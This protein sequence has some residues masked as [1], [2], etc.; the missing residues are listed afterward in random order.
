MPVAEIEQSVKEKL[1]KMGAKIVSRGRGIVGAHRVRVS[2][3]VGDRDS[4][5]PSGAP[6]KKSN[7]MLSLSSSS[8]LCSEISM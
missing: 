2:S 8:A 6:L 7:E 3:A 4:L 5:S 1:I